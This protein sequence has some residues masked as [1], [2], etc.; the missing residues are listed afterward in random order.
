[1][2]CAVLH[3]DENAGGCVVIQTPMFCAGGF[4]MRQEGGG[5]GEPGSVATPE[6][7]VSWRLSWTQA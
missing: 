5:Q 3:Q 2:P 6:P 1:M 7:L 4:A